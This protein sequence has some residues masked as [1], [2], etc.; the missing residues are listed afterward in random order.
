MN[1]FEKNLM[2]EIEYKK[3]LI[4]DIV[5]IIVSD[6]QEENLIKNLYKKHLFEMS[7]CFSE[8]SQISYIFTTMNIIDLVIL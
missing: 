2:E 7:F 3:F 4:E 8:A 6:S 1:Y 5:E